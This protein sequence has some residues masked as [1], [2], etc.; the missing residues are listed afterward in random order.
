MNKKHFDNVE[1]IQIYIDDLR[2]VIYRTEKKAKDLQ[3]KIRNL[4]EERA[5]LHNI[6]YYHFH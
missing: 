4:N 2:V 1:D 6:Y 5:V 3:E